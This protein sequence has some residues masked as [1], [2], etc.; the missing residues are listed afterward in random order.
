MG[1]AFCWWLAFGGEVSE[2]G[3]GGG[4]AVV[5]FGGDQSSEEGGEFIANRLRDAF[6]PILGPAV[7]N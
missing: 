1:W 6:S 2:D 5:F 7:A 3:G 4:V